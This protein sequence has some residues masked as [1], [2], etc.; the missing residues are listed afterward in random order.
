MIMNKRIIFQKRIPSNHCLKDDTWEED[1]SCW[2]RFEPIKSE[3]EVEA[4][5][6]GIYI[7]IIFSIRKSTK[8]NVLL[9]PFELNNYRVK[10]QEDIYNIRAISE[11]KKNRNYINIEC[12]VR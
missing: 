3:K 1:F 2:A 8:T 11:D 7:V 6:H 10:Y 4:N 5:F 12:K 9:K